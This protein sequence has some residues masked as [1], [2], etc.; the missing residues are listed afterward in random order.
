MKT[1]ISD[2]KDKYDEILY[3]NESKWTA[4]TCSKMDESYKQYTK[5]RSQTQE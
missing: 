4:T 1:V 5:E 3:S 2:R